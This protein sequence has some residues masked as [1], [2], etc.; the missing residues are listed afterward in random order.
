MTG[1]DTSAD[2]G[3]ADGELVTE[4]LTEVIDPENFTP[5]LL[6]LLSNALVW[7]ESHE[8]RRRFRLG[9]NDW[10]VIS[11][12]ALRP[13]ASATE[14]SEFIGVNKAVVSKS[15]NTLATRGLI[16]LVEGPRGSRPLY[17]TR[18]GA[19]MH[20]DMLPVSLSNQDLV[21]AE[22]DDA[23][24]ELLNSFLRRMIDRMR[25]ISSGDEPLAHHTEDEQP[26]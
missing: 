10:R 6:A 15:V 8:L 17:L 2:A 25:E 22:L 16:V 4:P 1:D 26:S 12:L 19:Q 18:A 9:T 13:G 3:R 24:I 21:H 7:R 23:Q 5:R 14:V 20:D 11:V